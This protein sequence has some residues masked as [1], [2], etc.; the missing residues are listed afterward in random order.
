MKFTRVIF[1]VLG[2][3]ILVAGVSFVRVKYLSAPIALAEDDDDEEEDD[4]DNNS[5]TET[6]VT[7]ETI[8]VKLPDIVVEKVTQV[9]LHDS[10]SDGLY[11]DEDP[12]PYINRFFVVEDKNLNGIDDAYEKFDNQ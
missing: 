10:D 1:I 6:V 8:Y 2:I 4:D 12:F 3:A 7:Y 9:P 11:D 5:N